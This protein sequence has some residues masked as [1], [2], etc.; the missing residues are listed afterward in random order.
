MEV[1]KDGVSVAKYGDSARVG[2]EDEARIEIASGSIDM[3]SGTSNIQKV[4]KF[5]QIGN[6]GGLQIYDNQLPSTPK[7]GTLFADSLS[8]GDNDDSGVFY[9]NSLRNDFHM[10][11]PLSVAG[12]INPIGYVEDGYARYSTSIPNNTATQLAYVVLSEGT[13]MVVCGVRSPS[14]AN[15]NRMAN[16]STVSGDS[17]QYDII[18]R[19]ASGQPTQLQFT[20]VVTPTTAKTYYLNACHDAGVTLSYP[21]G[22]EGHNNFIRAVR[23]A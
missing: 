1:Y 18:Q 19:A 6:A 9:W 8:F 13:W 2:K 4:A 5:T 20:V 14:N 7:I 12:H 16:L 10:S 21:A 22:S 23:I 3:Y 11:K 17:S 15:G